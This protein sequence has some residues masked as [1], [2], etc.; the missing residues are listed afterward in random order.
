MPKTHDGTAGIINQFQKAK[1]DSATC[2]NFE[3]KKFPF[4]DRHRWTS[5]KMNNCDNGLDTV[6]DPPPLDM[7]HWPGITDE[8]RD[9][10]Q[11]LLD[12]LS[13]DRPATS[14]SFSAAQW[15]A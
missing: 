6:D 3:F 12:P 7:C 10:Q 2:C 9:E 1:F 8:Q 4:L 14:C 11:D 5:A 15:R 13:S